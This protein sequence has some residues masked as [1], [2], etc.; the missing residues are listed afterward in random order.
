MSVGSRLC[1]ALN[2]PYSHY[3]RRCKTPLLSRWHGPTIA[4]RWH[5]AGQ[6]PDGRRLS[7][8]PPDGQEPALGT[9]VCITHLQDL[10][11][12]RP[13]GVLLEWK[14]IDGILAV[15]QGGGF[16]ALVNPFSSLAGGGHRE[17]PIWTHPEESLVEMVDATYEAQGF[18]PYPPVATR[19]RRYLFFS[20]PYAVFALDLCSLSGWAAGNRNADFHTLLDCT[21]ESDLRIAAAPIPLGHTPYRVG[22]LLYQA[23]R[24]E[25]RWLVLDVPGGG[26]VRPRAGG[27]SLV[28]PV[29]GTLPQ[30]GCPCQ[31]A[32][33]GN[34]PIAQPTA[35][36]GREERRDGKTDAVIALSTTQGHWLWRFSD[37]LAGKVD[38][39]VRTWPAG[40]S[41]GTVCLDYHIEDRRRFSFPRQRVTETAHDGSGFEWYYQCSPGG[42]GAGQLEYYYV[43][44][45]TLA[46]NLPTRAM[47][48][49]GAL[50][51]GPW[52]PPDSGR[53]SE[54]IFLDTTGD[55]YDCPSGVSPMNFFDILTDFNKIVGLWLDDPILMVLANDPAENRSHEITI[56]SLR[57]RQR[58]I[59]AGRLRLRADPLVWARWLF[60]CQLDGANLA[61]YR[62]E[63]PI[64]TPSEEEPKSDHEPRA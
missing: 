23:S 61:I 43:P 29:R 20:T 13:P 42:I 31:V 33:S 7:P 30:F 55:L 32:V 41:A 52:R 38:A 37:A 26:V 22:I 19:D 16:M 1:T 12:A 24:N 17:L 54:M 62:S 14:F 51:L 64:V 21:A 28:L 58:R 60:T 8:V 10:E 45:G 39:M 15:H 40:D 5:K 27:E 50:P 48:H 56:L 35:R 2:R 53:V 59:R 6:F 34:Q 47:R 46:A 4:E 3:C 63:L 25:Y 36:G 57:D 11:G 44:L 9:T 18:R 49:A